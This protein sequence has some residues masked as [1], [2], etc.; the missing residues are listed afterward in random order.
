MGRID[1]RCYW[2]DPASRSL[3]ILPATVLGF[4]CDPHRNASTDHVVPQARGGSGH[5]QPAAVLPEWP[6]VLGS[7]LSA[8]W[9]IVVHGFSLRTPSGPIRLVLR[10]QVFLKQGD[11]LGA[12]ALLGI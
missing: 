5:Q 4:R 8:R 6:P 2:V 3:G 1:L 9:P 12:I 7:S 11:P 10:K